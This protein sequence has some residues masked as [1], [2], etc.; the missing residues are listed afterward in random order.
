MNEFEMYK[1][2]DCRIVYN[3]IRQENVNPDNILL[4][5]GC[6]KINTTVQ[7][8]YVGKINEG[9]YIYKC[10][11]PTHEFIIHYA[12]SMGDAPK[13]IIATSLSRKEPFLLLWKKISNYLINARRK[14]QNLPKW[15]SH[16]KIDS[17]RC[18]CD[19]KFRSRNY[20]INH[21]KNWCPLRRANEEN[22]D[23]RDDRQLRN[24]KCYFDP[25]YCKCYMFTNRFKLAQKD[26]NNCQFMKGR[27]RR[28]KICN[29]LTRGAFDFTEI[30]SRLKKFQS[31]PLN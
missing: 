16:M 7:T 26:T 30:D 24:T 19:Q 1:P 15:K 28:Y 2:I 22:I 9:Y 8:V 11:N 29:I 17:Y 25:G 27:I 18:L 21:K 20:Y 4:Y 31:E 13:L 12:P 23:I 10:G 3:I 5:F 6:K 14:F